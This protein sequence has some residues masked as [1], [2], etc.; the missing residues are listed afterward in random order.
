MTKVLARTAAISSNDEQSRLP[1]VT[2]IDSAEVLN[3]YKAVAFSRYAE[4][5]LKRYCLWSVTSF[6]QQRGNLYRNSRLAK[7]METIAIVAGPRCGRREQR[8]KPHAA[9]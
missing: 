7:Q 5:G 8:R 4:D 9:G 1:V 6:A 2:N 3:W